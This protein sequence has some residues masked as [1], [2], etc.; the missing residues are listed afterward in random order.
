MNGKRGK[1]DVQEFS[2]ALADNIMVLR[3]DLLHGSYKHGGYQAF[4]ISDPKP[5]YIHKAGVRDRLLHHAIYRVLYPFFE[6]TFISDSYSCRPRKGTHRAIRR[7]RR[8]AYKAGNNNKRTCWVLKCDIKK[9]FASVDHGVLMTIL[10]QY[11]PDARI[12]DLLGGIVGSFSSGRAGKGLPLGN[13]TSQLF[14]NVYMNRFDQFVKHGL[15]AKYYIRYSDDFVIL[16]EKRPWLEAQIEPIGC[17]LRDELQLE[18]HPK[19]LSIKTLVSGV[20]F[21][22]TVHFPDHLVLRTKTKRRMLHKIPKKYQD[23]QRGV[24]SKE[25]FNQ[26]LQS[27]SGLLKHCNGYSIL[28][29]FEKLLSQEGQK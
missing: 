21:L 2:F 11:I 14:V 9:F 5:R 29:K 28:E 20:D 3:G 16:S 12:T 7:F 24:I 15:K 19:K 1:K 25:S 4:N 27:Y 8:L 13:L 22:G 18:L 23:F 26:S 6:R 10:G 17:F